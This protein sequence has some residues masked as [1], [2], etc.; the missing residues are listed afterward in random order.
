[1]K[2][3]LLVSH[4]IFPVAMPMSVPISYMQFLRELDVMVHTHCT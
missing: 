1:M 3:N 4:P 2:V